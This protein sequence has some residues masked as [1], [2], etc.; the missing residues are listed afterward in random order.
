MIFLNTSLQIW[1]QTVRDVFS[2]VQFLVL[3]KNSFKEPDIIRG[4]YIQMLRYDNI[5]NIIRE[6]S[7]FVSYNEIICSTLANRYNDYQ[8]ILVYVTEKN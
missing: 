6:T 1:R 8:E 7:N 2:T 3:Y 5:W 4:S